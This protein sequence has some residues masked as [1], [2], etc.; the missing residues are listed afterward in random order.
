NVSAGTVS[1]NGSGGYNVTWSNTYG[2]AG[3][4]PLKVRIFNNGVLAAVV[5]TTASVSPPPLTVLGSSLATSAGTVLNNVVI[6]RFTDPNATHAPD[7]YS[8]LVDFGDGN[9][10]DGTIVAEGGGSF[11]VTASDTYARAG[12]YTVDVSINDEEGRTA[13]VLSTVSVAAS[14][15]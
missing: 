14:V 4:F 3:D 8:A 9:L 13:D 12:T 5:D 7:F 10:V 1:A 6:A 11:V 2:A 15:P